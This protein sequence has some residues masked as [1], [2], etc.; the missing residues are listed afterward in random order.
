MNA[1]G[2]AI[3]GHLVAVAAERR[4]RAADPA[5]ADSVREIKRFQHT[6]FEQSYADLLA[7]PRYAKS[8][9]FFLEELYGPADFTARDRKSVV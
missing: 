9:R 1:Q 8:A 4:T 7:Q 5:L 2:Q 6:R 3:L